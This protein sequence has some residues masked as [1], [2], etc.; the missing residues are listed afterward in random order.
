MPQVHNKHR[1]TAPADSVYIGRGSTY[2]NP[3][4]IGK[5]GTRAEVIAKYIAM[6]EANQARK[7]LFA[8]ALRG[9][10]LVCFCKPA[11]CHGDYLLRIANETPE[12]P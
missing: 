12:C 10:D 7:K 11:Q 6:L 2:G 3:F 5:H 8:D 1:G 9:K 4:V